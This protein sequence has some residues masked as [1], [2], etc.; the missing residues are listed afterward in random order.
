MV[1]EEKNLWWRKLGFYTNP[2][3]IK[4][5]VFDNKVFGQD[6][7]L[8]ELYYKIPAGTMS[9]IE[10]PLGT[11]KTT[12][13]KHI[14]SKFKGQGKV[15][16]F[17]CNRIDSELN[18]EE[19]LRGKYGFWGKLFGMMPKD[20]IVLLDEAQQLSPANTERIKYFFDQGHIK[21]AI[22]TGTDYETA[23]L[24]QSVKE[25][26]GNDGLF[27]VKELSDEEAIVLVRNRVGNSKII[28]DEVIRELWKMSNKIPRRLL[29]RLDAVF[30]YSVEN[31][32]AEIKLDD[33]S[34]IFPI[35]KKP[36]VEKKEEKPKMEETHVKKEK[37]SSKKV[38]KEKKSEDEKPS[39]GK[40]Q[41]EVFKA[42]KNKK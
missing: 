14:I 30:K 7:I 40:S 38:R 17:S 26:I 23:N 13:M 18:M 31:S 33:L 25:R 6:K 29:Q 42:M 4:P 3:T 36:S 37:K 8:E 34:R 39:E 19:L 9:F 15:I 41:E 2:F 24:H 32:E 27:K 11:G 20:M 35:I 28:S 22:L 12:M 5:A 16:F 10:G 21:S 1:D